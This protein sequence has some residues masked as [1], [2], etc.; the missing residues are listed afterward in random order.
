VKTTIEI[1]EPLFR[2]AKAAAAARGESLRELVSSAL[3]RH[4]AAQ[5]GGG[6]ETEGWRRVFGKARAS[7]VAR[8]DAVVAADLERIDP[9]DWR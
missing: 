1:P 6:Q 2:E 7:D 8:V 3:R 4:L 5:A 9:A